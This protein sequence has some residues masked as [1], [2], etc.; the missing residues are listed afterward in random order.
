[1]F[2]RDIRQSIIFGLDFCKKIPFFIVIIL[3]LFLV[4]YQE[5]NNLS[6]F[7]GIGIPFLSVVLSVLYFSLLYYTIN[8]E[9]FNKIKNPFEWINYYF[10]DKGKQY[11]KLQIK[12]V[13]IE[14]FLFRYLPY[15]LFTDFILDNKIMVLIFAAIVFSF[16][17]K[18]KNT[19]SFLEFFLFFFTLHCLFMETLNFNVLFLPH[20]IR[21]LIIEFINRKQ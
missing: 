4:I 11:L 2:L 5:A 3:F 14:E 1:M 17:H 18:F 13:F 16:I 7:L 9:Y 20:L 15:L 10:R 12:G 21:N 19:I 6:I 8:K